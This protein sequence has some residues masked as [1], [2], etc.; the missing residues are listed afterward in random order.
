MVDVITWI[1]AMFAFFWYVQQSTISKYIGEGNKEKIGNALVFGT[2]ISIV[3]GISAVIIAY[4]LADPLLLMF[5]PQKV[6]VVED[7][8]NTTTQ[9]VP[10]PDNFIRDMSVDA[11]RVLVAGCPAIFCISSGTGNLMGVHKVGQS[12]GFALVAYLIAIIGAT[13]A[14]SNIRCDEKSLESCPADIVDNSACKLSLSKDGWICPDYKTFLNSASFAFVLGQ[15]ISAAML[16][17]A[18][19]LFA[20]R[21]Q[22]PLRF[23]RLSTYTNTDT[24]NLFARITAYMA[25]RAIFHNSYDFPL[26]LSA[27]AMIQVSRHLGE[28]NV[29]VA[30]MI[31]NDYRI[32]AVTCGFIFGARFL[33]LKDS[34][35]A[36]Y[37]GKS[38]TAEFEEMAN[39]VWFWVV[40]YQP[41]FSLLAVYSGLISGF[42]DFV[43]WGRTVMLTC[44]VVYLPL[45]I[46]ASYTRNLHFLIAAEVMYSLVVL[47]SCY[48]KLHWF[49]SYG[50]VATVQL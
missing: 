1:S 43:F 39:G 19:V 34:T 9:S 5:S 44:V 47:V 22:Y 41:I 50:S 20:R 3:C 7:S 16:V 26:I 23:L 45:A 48:V 49:P 4:P 15:Y 35:I 38:Q 42:Q 25:L 11:L 40:L 31:L 8:G 36:E 24:R 37:V 10:V 18:V 27:V 30:T 2:T 14:L 21:K 6:E 13:V 33:I 29:K 17:M 32:F 46:A 12:V 28:N